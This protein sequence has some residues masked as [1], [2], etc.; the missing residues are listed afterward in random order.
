MAQQS[1]RLHRLLTL[2]DTGSTQATRFTAARQ[3]GDIAKAH[4][5]DLSSLLKMVLLTSTIAFVQLHH[6]H[7]IICIFAALKV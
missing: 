2:L 1:S 7:H 6:A 5:H 3:I 4:P